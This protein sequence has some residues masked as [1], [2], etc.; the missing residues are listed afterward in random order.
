MCLQISMPAPWCYLNVSDMHLLALWLAC[1][2]T[3]LPAPP[4]AP[5]ITSLISTY[6]DQLTVTWTS[7]PTATSYNVSINASDNTLVPIPSIGAQQYN[8]TGLTNNTVYTVSV[9]AINCAGSSSPA[10]MTGRTGETKYAFV[11]PHNV[12]CYMYSRCKGY[13]YLRMEFDIA[14]AQ[15]M[16]KV[17]DRRCTSVC[18]LSSLFDY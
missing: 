18:S 13:C 2:L 11:W 17:I 1:H 5:T 7:V 9:M 4:S 14:F 12:V 16:L 6:S 8:F 15:V 3:S 10:K